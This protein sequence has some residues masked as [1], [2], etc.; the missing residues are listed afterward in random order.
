MC[1]KF[2]SKDS[3]MPK[4]YLDRYKT[5]EMDVKSVDA[6]AFLSILKFIPD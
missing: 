4:Y 6:D 1:D 3:F 5:Q 2:V